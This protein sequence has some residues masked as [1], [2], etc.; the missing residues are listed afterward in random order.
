MSND[1]GNSGILMQEIDNE[2]VTKMVEDARS[3]GLLDWLNIREDYPF[4]GWE[5]CDGPAHVYNFEDGSIWLITIEGVGWYR[6]K[7]TKT[8]IKA[9]YGRDKDG[10]WLAGGGADLQVELSPSQ[11][12]K[13]LK[14]ELVPIESESVVRRFGGRLESNLALNIS[15]IKKKQQEIKLLSEEE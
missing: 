1:R 5:V 13:L 11:I 12:R 4:L 2:K 15:A 6:N 8:P 14:P 10:G 3:K 7:P 9:K